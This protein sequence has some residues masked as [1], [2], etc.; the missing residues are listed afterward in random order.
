MGW[1]AM[2]WPGRRLGRSALRVNLTP[3]SDAR[4]LIV[5]RPTRDQRAQAFEWPAP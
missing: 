5:R 4:R 1:L 2:A 3:K